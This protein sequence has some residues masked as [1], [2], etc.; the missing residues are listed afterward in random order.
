MIVTIS[1]QADHDMEEI[2]DYVALDNPR[3]AVSFLQELRERVYQIADHPSAAPVRPTLG[4]GVRGLVHGNYTIF[5]R[6]LDTQ[7]RVERV[8]HTARDVQDL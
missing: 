5:Y 3:R 2:G 6:V 7:I 8:L 1:P 4:P